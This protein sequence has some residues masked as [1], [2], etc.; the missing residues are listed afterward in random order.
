MSVSL[1]S[2]GS[3]EGHGKGEEGGDK[4]EGKGINEGK[5]KDKGKEKEKKGGGVFSM[6]GAVMITPKKGKAATKV[7]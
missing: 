2:N 6:I 1:H 4:E 5:G 7:S 3:L